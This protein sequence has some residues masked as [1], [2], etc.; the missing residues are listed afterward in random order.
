MNV[1]FFSKQLGR[2]KVSSEEKISSKLYLRFSR[3][4]L[5]IQAKTSCTKANSPP[6]SYI[7]LQPFRLLFILRPGLTK[8]PKQVLNSQSSYLGLQSISTYVYISQTK[9][10]GSI[11]SCL[12]I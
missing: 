7:Y 11:C 1:N 3:G 12:L 6:M 2:F 8:L 10:Y 9:L 5:G 4:I